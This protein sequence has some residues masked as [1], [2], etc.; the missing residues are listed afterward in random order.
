VAE[1]TFSS[2]AYGPVQPAQRAA[3]DSRR[4]NVVLETSAG[5]GELPEY[6][7]LYSYLAQHSH[8]CFIIFTPDHSVSLSPVEAKTALQRAQIFAAHISVEDF[9]VCS[10]DPVSRN[11]ARLLHALA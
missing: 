8:V 5:E 3:Y 1:G 4:T 11:T 10:L 6:A 2:T 9:S 7:A